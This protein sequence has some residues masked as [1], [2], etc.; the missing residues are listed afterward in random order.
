[1]PSNSCRFEI[2]L[3]FYSI[4]FPYKHLQT[5]NPRIQ[6]NSHLSLSWIHWPGKFAAD[7]LVSELPT[8]NQTERPPTLSPLRRFCTSTVARG[9]IPNLLQWCNYGNNNGTVGDSDVRVW[10]IGRWCWCCWCSHARQN[11]KRNFEILGGDGR[12]WLICVDFA[13]GL[14]WTVDM[15]KIASI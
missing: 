4:L 9:C 5:I 11:H 12:S 3:A 13:Q 1:M 2:G 6:S 8:Q 14:L 15:R 7:S 10:V